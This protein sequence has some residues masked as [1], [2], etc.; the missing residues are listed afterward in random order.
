M[1]RFGASLRTLIAVSA[2]TVVVCAGITG[3]QA[4]PPQVSERFR[5]RLSAVDSLA[6]A[7]RLDTAMAVLQG[8]IRDARRRGDPRTLSVLLQTHAE[9]LERRGGDPYRPAREAFDL[10]AA[11]RDSAAI[12]AALSLLGTRDIDH[13]GLVEPAAE[14]LLR[15][16]LARDDYRFESRARTTLASDLLNQGQP[17]Q[18]RHGFTRAVELSR[19]AGDW[20]GELEAA[21]GLGHVHFALGNLDQAREAYRKVARIAQDRRAPFELARALGHVAEVELVA[22]DLDAA[23]ESQRRAWSVYRHI[24]TPSDWIGPAFATADIQKHLGLFDDAESTLVHVAAA[25]ESLGQTPYRAQAM[26]EHADVLVRAQ[27]PVDAASLARAGLN[28]GRALAAP[29]RAEL[30]LALARALDQQDSTAAALALIDRELRSRGRLPATTRLELQSTRAEMLLAMGRGREALDAYQR[31]RRDAP[32]ASD[33]RALQLASAVGLSELAMGRAERAAARLDEASRLWSRD[34]GGPYDLTESEG[35]RSG[36]WMLHSLIVELA[37]ATPGAPQSGARVAFDS[38]QT[39]RK[40]PLIERT[41]GP[42]RP[43]E[44]PSRFTQPAW[45]A[46]SLQHAV[47]RDDEILLDLWLG[48]SASYLFALTRD[49]LRLVR[50]PAARRLLRQAIT[51]TSLNAAGGE[52]VE[53]AAW[54]S[55]A[56]RLGAAQLADLTD[57]AARCRRIVFVADGELA[58]FPLGALALP[59]SS[60]APAPLAAS[61]F[62]ERY[63]SATWLGIERTVD[64]P[65][66]NARVLA[67]AGPSAENGAPS[68]RAEAEVEDLRS[69]YRNIDVRTAEGAGAMDPEQLGDHEGLH[70]VTR[71][72]LD[73]HHPWYSGILLDRPSRSD[74]DPY[75][76][77]GTIG[78]ARLDARL[79]VLPSCEPA[80]GVRVPQVGTQAMAAALL[81]AGAEAVLVQLWALDEATERRWTEAFY[82]RLSGGGTVA[83][84]LASAEQVVRGDPATRAPHHWASHAL[85]GNGEVRLPLQT[86]PRWWW[87]SIAG[88]GV[89]IAA[90]ALAIGARRRHHRARTS[91]V[92]A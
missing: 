4:P 3:A 15:M 87:P 56:A 67:L 20:R 84:A 28:L 12:M 52:G 13:D 32:A 41:L 73:D 44:I 70:L 26:A 43:L 85:F 69:R 66:A 71:T 46:D 57:L 83:E 53:Q 79:V 16:S 5:D 60:G 59:D 29:E 91:E 17:E 74:R 19:L 51:F 55:S 81:A 14:W 38:L 37:T 23:V 2:L 31:A 88:A 9:L 72:R 11:R 27:R 62:I 75:W 33:W 35:W 18:A 10:A 40:R 49:S 1:A 45:T 89:V 30:T 92:L 78:T 50:L 8:V 80:R 7:S 90:I 34:E 54:D 36:G 24:G 82:A 25:C 48:S 86:R 61:H 77:A 64:S 42:Q 6:E 76:R 21:T 68:S 22:G 63:P 58:A 47:L 65:E 39:L